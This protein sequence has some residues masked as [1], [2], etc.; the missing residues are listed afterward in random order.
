MDGLN[1]IVAIASLYLSA[2]DNTTPQLHLQIDRCVRVDLNAV[3]QQV[4]GYLKARL[5]GED[6][7]GTLRVSVV[8]QNRFMEI[9]VDDPQTLEPVVNAVQ[10]RPFVELQVFDPLTAKTLRR[11]FDL[12]QEPEEMRSRL[13]AMAISELVQASWL[14]LRYNPEPQVKPIGKVETPK[15]VEVAKESLSSPRFFWAPAASTLRM[16]E[17]RPF[18]VGGGFSVTGILGIS[19]WDLQ[20]MWL[21]AE[22]H[23]SSGSLRLSPTGLRANIG[24]TEVLGPARL[25]VGAGGRFGLLSIGAQPKS[26]AVTVP[27]Q[28]ST[29]WGGVVGILGAVW[30]AA[31]YVEPALELEA[32]YLLRGVTITIPTAP[33][34][35]V[36][37]P[38]LAAHIRLNFVL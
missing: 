16:A 11:S 14:E 20:A 18:L 37:G 15:V 25:F 23:R 24:L 9:R 1:W 31:R 26:L 21:T 33:S 28:G 32:G 29:L 38:W 19:Y 34:I 6:E 17:L 36:R 2:P 4:S 3:G 35:H 30:R 27:G 5:V 13:L 8:C 7:P 12:M 22:L 10:P